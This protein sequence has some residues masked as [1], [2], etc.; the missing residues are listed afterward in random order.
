MCSKATNSSC[1]RILLGTTESRRILEKSLK[2]GF[3]DA[4]IDK[5]LFNGSAG[6]GKTSMQK[7][8]A[9]EDPPK[10]RTSTPLATRPITIYQILASKGVWR[11]YDSDDRMKLCA[12]ISKT[13]IGN[14]IIET[15]KSKKPQ[16]EP[17]PPPIK[18][19]KAEHKA[20]AVQVED[21]NE[22]GLA[23]SER[24]E[25]CPNVIKVIH[26]VIDKMYQLIDE[27]PDGV[28][29]I[30]YLH[31]V[32]IVDCGGQPQFREI[33]PIFLRKLSMIVFVINLSEQLSTRP[34]IEYYENGKALGV[35]YK[36]DCTTE[37]LL[38]QGLQSIHSHRSNKDSKGESPRIVVVGT[39]KD[40]EK[41]CEE[42]REMKNQKL[43]EML[44]PA[45]S[46][47]VVYSQPATN[48]VIFAMNAKEPGEE[49][50]AVASAIRS[51]I[52]RKQEACPRKLPLMWLT[53]EIILEE[54]TKKL[55]RGVLTMRECQEIARRLRFDLS[56]LDA[57]LIYFDE[58]SLIFYYRDIL[59]G[60]VFTNPQVVHSK[61]S[62]LVK[63][64]H[65]KMKSLLSMSEAW[66]E[67][68]HHALITLE[69]LSQEMFNEHYV[70]GIFE[71][72]HVVLL[73]RKL[74][75][76][77]DYSERQ[78]FV[79]CLLR[80]LGD[81]E[82][83]KKRVALDSPVA[84]LVLRFPDGPPRHGIFCALVS[85]LTSPD[86]HFLNPWKIKMPPLS[87]T[88]MCLYRNCIQFTI[89]AAK[90][91]CSVTLIDTQLQF[92]VH[93]KV[94][95]KKSASVVCSSIKQAISTGLQKANLALGYLNSTPTFA[96]I[97]PCGVGH[98]HHATIGDGYW[99]CSL[100]EDNGNELN[101]NQCVWMEDK[102]AINITSSLGMECMI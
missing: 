77:A 70:P 44:L 75:I 84:P 93:L 49:E 10:V 102:S 63:I 36:S 60:L 5:I 59:P 51:M 54:I 3:I 24:A 82:V 89:P 62:E 50:E 68:Y 47:D 86:N 14:E 29:P 20:G 46:K 67:F 40:L 100:D 56:T 97:C 80:M 6:V 99:I 31:K 73:Y 17:K 18:R 95:P 13:V 22:K 74:L 90:C 53:L 39:H 37:Q 1:F 71:P 87:V 28:D 35:P 19:D 26:D 41:N 45:F 15:I 81:E 34:T 25:V 4:F 12:R 16:K 72:K 94:P 96:L 78:I 38:K 23:S 92:E 69:F 21:V 27:V 2:C 57:A 8:V 7:I 61:I 30:T 42:T 101:P 91:P 52:A 79:P 58:M 66:Q 64:H 9:G 48:D 33:L 88:P 98:N 76:F 43:R 85:F 83:S 11:R 32:R 55:D 65:D